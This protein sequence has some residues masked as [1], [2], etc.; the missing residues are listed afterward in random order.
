MKA[1]D[2]EGR[3]TMACNFASPI[4]AFWKPGKNTKKNVMRGILLDGQLGV[5]DMKAHEMVT[6]NNIFLSPVYEAHIQGTQIFVQHT[7][8]DS[9]DTGDALIQYAYRG[10]DPRWE[11]L[12]DTLSAGDGDAEAFS[13]ED[14]FIEYD[15]LNGNF[16]IQRR[17]A[18][19]GKIVWKK[20]YSMDDYDFGTCLG[21][22]DDSLWFD[23]SENVDH[24]EACR[25]M[26]G[27]DLGTGALKKSTCAMVDKPK[28]NYFPEAHSLM[29]TANGFLYVSDLSSFSAEGDASRVL[30]KVDPEEGT[31]KSRPIEFGDITS[32]ICAEPG[33]DAIF[34]FDGRKIRKERQDGEELF[35]VNAEEC[36]PRGM[37]VSPDGDLIIC[38]NADGQT[39]VYR[40]RA[41]N[42]KFIS[43]AAVPEDV[44]TEKATTFSLQTLPGGETLVGID[45]QAYLIGGDDWGVL[46]K[47]RSY[48]AYNEEKQQFF[49]R[50]DEGSGHIPYCSLSEMINRGQEEIQ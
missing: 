30:S 42:G 39:M 49:L 16:R 26:I 33:S 5:Y 12:K 28:A 31:I 11:S 21:T 29:E 32:V 44:G 24:G 15:Y 25:S 43:K 41:K 6:Q 40:Y 27:I 47:I 48:M 18:D 38:G 20:N 4:R 17:Q 46:S 3:E 8:A 37:G 45:K 50:G 2:Q 34:L 19:T 7:E 36:M 23:G 35:E 22:A 14:A 10:C 13:F 1:F 9:I